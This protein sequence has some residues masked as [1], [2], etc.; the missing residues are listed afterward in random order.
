MN[1]RAVER[2]RFGHRRIEIDARATKA[3]FACRSVRRVVPFERVSVAEQNAMLAVRKL[4]V[5]PVDEETLALRAVGGFEAFELVSALA[6]RGHAPSWI[7]AQV[8][9]PSQHDVSSA[10][11]AE[12]L[13]ALS[14][15]AAAG[16]T[17][18]VEIVKLLTPANA[19][20]MIGHAKPARKHIAQACRID[21]RRYVP[22]RHLTSGRDSDILARILAD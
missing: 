19:L 3:Y 7:S 20:A 14:H 8:I 6:L 9:E 11:Q 16:P 2:I 1:K 17:A 18:V 15:S 10:I 5:L 13:A 4:V 21:M 22:P 12:L